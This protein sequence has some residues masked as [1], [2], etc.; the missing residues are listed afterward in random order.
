MGGAI[1]SRYSTVPFQKKV[2][3]FY[4]MRKMRLKPFKERSMSLRWL[5]APSVQWSSQ[6]VSR[7]IGASSVH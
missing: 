6:V 7:L 5:E 3:G 4:S 1:D 2:E